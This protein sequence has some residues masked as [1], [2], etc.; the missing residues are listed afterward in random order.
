MANGAPSSLRL[1]EAGAKRPRRTAKIRPV[2]RWTAWGSAIV[3]YLLTIAIL[4]PYSYI[5]P[6]NAVKGAVPHSDVIA[7]TRL[8]V[9]DQQATEEARL[10]IVKT[11]KAIYVLN[12]TSIEN[13]A[14]QLLN[15]FVEEVIN[16]APKTSNELRTLNRKL[17]SSYDIG[18]DDS[19]LHQFLPDRLAAANLS[20]GAVKDNLNQIITSI[21]NFR[22]IVWDKALYQSHVGAGVIVV[23]NPWNQ[24][25]PVPDPSTVLDWREEVNNYLLNSALPARFPG[26]NL[27]EFRQAAAELLRAIL[28]PNLVYDS[29]KSQ[30]AYEARLKALE[31]NPRTKV[32]Q[33]GEL[34]A[35]KDVPL[36][37]LQA[38]ALQQINIEGRA[39]FARKMVGILLIT[40]VFYAAI[41]FY[42]RYFQKDTPLN[43]STITLHALPPIIAMAIGQLLLAQLGNRADLWFPAAIVG[44]LA[45]LLLTPRVAF[46]LVLAT[47]CL[48]G[49]VTGRD[50]GFIVFALFGGYAA[51][52]LSRRMRA[53]GE[54]LRVGVQVGLVNVVTIA[55]LALLVSASLPLVRELIFVFI[56]G[57]ACA[58]GTLILLVVFEKAFGIVTDLRL[59]ELTGLKHPLLAQ[60]EERSPG[61]YQHVLNVTKLA[62]AA[63]EAI[64]ANYLLVRAG[65]YFHDIGK[66]VKPKYYS[67]NQVT[68]DDKKAHSRLTPY[69]SVLIIKNHVKEGI[70]LARKAGLPQKVVDFIPQHHGTGLIRIFYTEALKR[71]ENSETVDPVHEEDFRY[72]G[73]KPQSVETAIVLL[74]DSVEA[75]AASRFTSGQVNINE[76]RRVVQQTISEKFLD[77]QFDEC[78]LTLRHLYLIREAFVR[79]L[80]ARYHFRI[81]YPAPPQRREPPRDARE[82]TGPIAIAG[83]VPTGTQG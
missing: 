57:L 14:R 7:T 2:R 19:S 66:M 30:S 72:P 4:T 11:K 21:L 5:K 47:S 52:M 32:F 60:L 41:A 6:Y 54:V 65:S 39:S 58:F 71:Y 13:T 73:P 42:L 37:Q 40:A 1:D 8:E 35:E 24:E 56:N 82:T 62:E 36:T 48:F 59:L 29:A 64:G 44:I 38:D 78:D 81:A 51:V 12:T 34:I 75:T 27:A 20:I 67:E 69:M 77:G 16:T 61:T 22:P 18:L 31:A 26:A 23:V 28:K 79:T 10:Q 49:I 15:G 9:K 45:S 17:R 80:M 55:I 33:A 68:L 25:E 43:A 3:W 46:A 70:E 76:L 74:A 63:A 50:L 53:R 83:P